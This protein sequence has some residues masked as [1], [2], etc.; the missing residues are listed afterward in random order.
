MPF[1]ISYC[2][3]F[4]QLICT[5][6]YCLVF[7][8]MPHPCHCRRISLFSVE[9]IVCRKTRMLIRQRDMRSLLK[10]RQNTHTHTH[11]YFCQMCRITNGACHTTATNAS[12]A[13][14]AATTQWQWLSVYCSELDESN[15]RLVCRRRQTAVT[16]L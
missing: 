15:C 9:K 16:S 8:L 3:V 11:W 4:L 10:N 6:K 2:H 1:S 7:S 14:A 12:V 5:F 13:T